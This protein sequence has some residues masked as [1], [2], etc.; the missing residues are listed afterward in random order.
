MKQIMSPI[1]YLIALLLLLCLPVINSQQVS[2]FSIL[3]SFTVLIAILLGGLAWIG[4]V[5]ALVGLLPRNMAALLFIPIIMFVVLLRFTYQGLIEFSGAGFTQ[6]FFVHLQ[7]HSVMLAWQ[8][9]PWIIMGGVIAIALL[10]VWSLGSAQR[11]PS[12]RKKLI[13]VVLLLGSLLFISNSYSYM[14]ERQFYHAVKRWYQPVVNLD[15]ARLAV[16]QEY[17][18]VET[19]LPPK[20]RLG[21]QLPEKPL[22]VIILFMESVGL[23]LL[24]HPDYPGLL[25]N[26]QRLA[27]E[28]SLVED[29]V[30]S[31]YVTIEGMVNSLCGTLFPFERDS[32][33]LA[34]SEG[35]AERMA[36]LPDILSLAGYQQHYLGGAAL[37][38]AKKGDF[39]LA[40]GF[41]IARGAEYWDTIS[42]Y[43]R[44]DTFGVSD[45]D[46]FDISHEEITRLRASGKPFNLTLLTI[47]T[48]TPG[49]PYEECK[50]YPGIDDRYLHALHCTDQLI[51]QWLEKLRADKQL[52]DT[53]VV[54]TADHHIFSSPD[55]ITLFGRKT[56]DNRKL[57]LI[58]LS[59]APIEAIQKKGSAYDLAPTVL[60]ILKINHNAKFILGRSLLQ[61]GPE[62]NYFFKRYADV[63]EGQRIAHGK[64][65]DTQEAE[66]TTPLNA[67]QRQ[68]LSQLLNTLARG[69]SD[70]YAQ[71]DCRNPDHMAIGVDENNQLYIN[72]DGKDQISQFVWHGWSIAPEMSG[73]YFVTFDNHGAVDHRIFYPDDRIPASPEDHLNSSRWVAVWNGKKTD[74]LPDWLQP[75]TPAGELFIWLKTEQAGIN[76]LYREDYPRSWSPDTEICQQLAGSYF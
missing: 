35:M 11:L 8:E 31:G 75:E 49:Y 23:P 7:W 30:T 46:L 20:S 37:D 43:P 41:D 4:V 55:M 65:D 58:V 63:Y 27:K 18:A 42:L 61:S 6:E 29:Y 10:L 15:P 24:D 33:A 56:A 25:P 47:G 69:M 22:N 2:S 71:L 59:P 67:C 44:P 40:H 54:I 39:L 19:D 36:C 9:Y 74:V 73:I 16:W 38:F 51:H 12:P 68:E 26:L 60:D 17:P 76:H 32:D 1:F 13:S 45:V 21:A 57:P 3:P 14:P 48:H 72:I 28:H 5:I 70:S 50:P 64:C 62:R 52:E 53:V 66:L 34:G